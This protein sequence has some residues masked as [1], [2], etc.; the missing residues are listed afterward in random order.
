VTVLDDTGRCPIG[1]RCEC[2]GLESDDLAAVAADLGW[3]GIA[4]LTMCRRCA[5]SAISPPVA[6]D[7][8]TRLVMQ[9]S[10]HLGVTADDM[11]ALLDNHRQNGRTYRRRPR[12][13]RRH[14]GGGGPT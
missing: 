1:I 14:P 2:C 12:P 5:D 7:T 8:A 13:Q 11:R 3:I 6:V 10:M 9:H 4:C